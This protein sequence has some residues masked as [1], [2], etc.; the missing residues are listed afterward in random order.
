[1]CLVSMSG[2]VLIFFLH[3]R[4]VSGL[5]ALATGALLCVIVYWIWV[6]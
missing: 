5:I 4:L 3:K 1:M 6:P 2:L